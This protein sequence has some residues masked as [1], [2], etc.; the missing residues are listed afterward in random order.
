[1]P[2]AV[3][4][5][6]R[7]Y[8]DRII[9]VENRLPWHLGTDLKHFKALTQDHVII[10]GRKTFESLGRPLPNR[11]NIVLSREKIEDRAN[12]FWVQNL[13]TALL[14]ADF[15]SICKGKKQFFVIGGEGIYSLFN[16]YINKVFLTD[17]NSGPINGDAKFDFDFPNSEWYYQFE[18]EFQKSEI[19]DYSFR[20]SY[21]VRRKPEHRKRM[22]S[23][24]RERNKLFDV[25]WQQFTADK[26]VADDERHIERAQLSFLG[27]L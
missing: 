5:V 16:K 17:V 27:R 23:E 20:I 15:H 21:I 18:R 6:A 11:I 25:N 22:I 14:L 10:M 12:L 24:F 13:E 2:S 1:M 7:S 9:G 19:D 4:V 8:P 3:S 26:D